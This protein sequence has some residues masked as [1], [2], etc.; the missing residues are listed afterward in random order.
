MRTVYGGDC[1]QC[2]S[3]KGKK[4]YAET[5]KS[6]KSEIKVERPAPTVYFAVCTKCKTK[7]TP[8]EFYSNPTTKSKLQSQCK[9]CCKAAAKAKRDKMYAV[10][11]QKK[12]EDKEL[13][14]ALHRMRGL[15]TLLV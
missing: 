9:D 6:S 5:K 10:K 12:Q 8:N 14:N 4:R 2:I 7:K 11:R 1:K 3:K 13:I 15:N